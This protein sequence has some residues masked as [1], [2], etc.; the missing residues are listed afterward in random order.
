MRLHAFFNGLT[1]FFQVKLCRII[2]NKCRDAW[3]WAGCSISDGGGEWDNLVFMHDFFYV[4]D[5]AAAN[6][7]HGRDPQHGQNEGGTA[8]LW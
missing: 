4:G 5:M 1:S 2:Y 8:F 7:E 3:R 6:M